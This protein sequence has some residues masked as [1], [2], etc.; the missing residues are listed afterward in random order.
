M[1]I[2]Q[3]LLKFINEPAYKP[4]EIMELAQ[5]FNINK[6]EYNAFK[7][8]IKAMERENLIVR[9][10]AGRIGSA[11]KEGTVEGKLQVH[12]KGFGFVIPDDEEKE[13]IFIPINSINGAM[14]GDR[15]VA[16]ILK[17]DTAKKKCEGEI[18]SVTE[19]A[20]KNVIGVYQ[21]SRNFG[22]VISEDKR[23]PKDI[24]ISKKDKNGAAD[25]DVVI[26]E[27]TKWAQA[28]KKPE[29]KIKE[30]VGKKGDVGIDILTIIKKH[31]LPEQFPPKVLRYA[32][33]VEDEIS[34][35]E[36]A[37]RKDL[38]NIRMV[39]IDGEDAKDLDDAVS[40]ERLED[41]NYKLGVH[42][43]DVSHYVRENN[44]LDKEAFK[45]ATS[46]YL[47]DRVIPM[48]PKKLSNGICSLNP[49]V[50]RLALSCIMTIDKQGK[51]LD[52]E[53]AE[54]VIRTSERMTYTDVTKILR[55]HDEEL[56]KKYDYLYD[57]FKA[58]EEL[59]RILNAKRIKRGAIDFEFE[60]SKIIL[61]EYGKPIE[62]KP[63][64]REIANRMIEEFMLV[65]NETV[66]EHMYW[67]KIPFVY[68]IHEDPNEEK[69]EKFKEF[70]YNLGYKI[71]WTN[72]L[73]PA[74]FQHILELVKGKKEETVVSTLLL[75]SM[76]QARY[77]PECSG[78]FG[79][80][81]RFY[82]HFT[83]PIRRY[84]DLQIHR[85][86]KQFLHGEI[87]EKRSTKLIG[88]V[89]AASKQS[90]EM[91]RVAQDAER[92]VDDL[93][94]TEYMGD[95]IGEEFEGIVSSVTSFGM[96]VELPNTIEGLI[97]M[98]DLTDDYY[99]YDEAQLA[100][101]GERTKKTYKLGDAVKVK[102]DR[103]SIENREIYF[104]LVEDEYSR[105]E[106]NFEDYELLEQM[107]EEEPEEESKFL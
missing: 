71:K 51:V 72:E 52:H 4:M 102:C 30:V 48:L 40:I 78:H 18:I 37:G 42:I 54:T 58:M 45:R 53:I 24:F 44:P 66:A 92:E 49:R 64:E 6:N 77:A 69:L 98:N 84:P 16:K 62:I 88:I 23:I 25:G 7:K 63:Y 87:D 38:R 96:F 81:A 28:D 73:H 10:K 12:P 50:D 20:N 59:C 5:I 91:E 57:D 94:K 70:M 35:K 60:E 39:T 82:C 41:G 79:L 17:E 106:K 8:V 93:K 19:R 68:R 97:R 103:V 55:D 95:R 43:A 14:N 9:D 99:V 1:G 46:V 2:K 74:T 29:G 22:F 80:S 15:V 86:I 31:G 107:Q 75:R 65:C 89:D 36:I 11:T 13:D 33:G 76:M 56:I 90:S 61:N 3:T 100:L 105:G 101:V 26:V 83:S 27:I 67:T 47:I 21:D 32:D 85:I 104:T 34:E